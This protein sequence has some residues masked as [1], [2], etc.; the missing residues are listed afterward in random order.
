MSSIIQHLRF[1]TL[2]AEHKR[3]EDDLHYKHRR[4]GFFEDS[5]AVLDDLT[6]EKVYDEGAVIAADLGNKYDQTKLVGKFPFDIGGHNISKEVFYIKLP[7]NRE[8]YFIKGYVN[9]NLKDG[10]IAFVLLKPFIDPYYKWLNQFNFKATSLVWRLNL[11]EVLM[12]GVTSNII[13]NVILPKE[14][15]LMTDF[16]YSK[17]GASARKKLLKDLLKEKKYKL[18]QFR[19]KVLKEQDILVQE[20]TRP[21]EIDLA[22]YSEG[23]NTRSREVAILICT[24]ERAKAFEHLTQSSGFG[25]S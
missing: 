10:V 8:V 24:P 13:K 4:L 18:L 15:E 7:E 1:F 2:I 3:R 21:E 16:Y 6:Y 5:P 17:A 11:Q 19:Y 20:I 22:F 12:P 23:D 25:L 9:D 14:G